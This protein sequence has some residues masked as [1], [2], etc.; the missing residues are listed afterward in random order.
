[1]DKILLGCSSC[2]L[3]KEVRYDGGHKYDSWVV[4]TL[5]AFADYFDLCPEHQC[6]MPIPREA[7][8]LK[9][10]KDDYRMLSNKTAHDFTDQMLNW[11]APR[12]EELRKLPLCGYILKSK[13]PSCGMERVKVYPL[14]GGA[15][16][17]TGVGIFA[18]ELLAAFPLLPVEEE[19]RLHDPVLRENFIERVF[20]MQRWHKLCRE[21][22][23]PGALVRF[24]T[25]HKY[26]LMAHS[27]AHYRSM[28]KLVAD[29]RKYPPEDFCRIYFEEL[30][31]AMKRH[32]T[33]SK[34]QNVLLHILGYFKKDLDPFEK[35][36]LIRL[37]SM[38]KDAL[39]PL[40]V[41]ITLLNHYVRKYDKE[42]LADQVYL[43]P[44]PMELKLRNHA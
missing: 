4:D 41:P 28:G 20:I 17:K 40:I 36:E 15:A 5:G 34:H 26:L 13:S 25:I 23:N 9:G 10:S 24:H 8:N 12:I 31:S 22:L 33:P 16:G 35:Q 42:Y 2:L 3:G 21:G 39:I 38:H 43:N 19:G 7:L 18:R 14:H 1:M 27:P 11:C 29:L 32:A 30:M 6:G 37:I 44:H